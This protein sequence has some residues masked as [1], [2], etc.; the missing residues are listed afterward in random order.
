VRKSK[1]LLYILAA[2]FLTVMIACSTK[3]NTAMSR[4]YHSVTTKYNIL[5]NGR[6][7]YEKGI[8]SLKE[9]YYDDFYNILPVERMQPDEK[10]LVTAKQKDPNFQRAEDKAI[11]ASQLHSIYIAGTENNPQMDEA[12]MLL[13]KSRYHDIR[14]IP[15]IEAFNYIILKY[16][17]SDL[18]YDARVWKEKAN[19][20]LNY[21]NL[22][23]KNLKRLLKEEE[24]KGQTKAD[25]L[26]TLAQG[27]INIEA[28]DSA[29]VPLKEAI[30]TTQDKDEKAR[31][32]YILGQ[33]YGKN[34]NKEEAVKTFQEII[35]YKYRVPRAYVINAHAE[36]FANQDPQK[37]DTVAFLKEYNALLADRE[38][39]GFH[40]VIYH[41]M[42]SLFNFYGNDAQAIANFNKSLKKITTN[43][44]LK[45][46]N[47][48]KLA[49][50]Y[51]AK[52]TYEMAG[53]YYDS[54]LVVMNPNSREY[55]K[56]KRLRNNLV[57]VVKYELVARENDSILRLVALPEEQR[58]QVLKEFLDKKRIADQA[59]EKAAEKGQGQSSVSNSLPMTGGVASSF[60]F[61]S[62]A[63]VQKGKQD[64]S[65]K[66]GKRALTDNW[67]WADEAQNAVANNPNNASATE[68]NASSGEETAATETDMRYNV[69]FFLSQI[70]KDENEIK[71]LKTDR[72]NAYYQLGLLYS[73]LLE[74][75][76]IAADKLETLLTYKPEERLIEPIKY[77]LYKIYLKLDPAKA[78][79]ML[80]DMK[81]NHPN[82]QYTQIILNP[83]AK[84]EID[85]SPVQEYEKIYT[86]YNHGAYSEVLETLNA[87]I[88]T[89]MNDGMVTKYEILKATTIGKLNGLEDYKKALNYVAVTYPNS[90]EGQE[91]QRIISKDL[92]KLQAL[93]FKNDLSKNLKLIYVVDF[94][95]T[96]QGIELRNKLQ[97]YANDRA[98]TGISFSADQ[99]SKDK[100]FLVIHGI[101]SG[102]IAKSAQ[103]YLEIE[104]DYQ[105]KE[106]PVLISSD[107][108]GVV[109]IK[110]NW[111]E[112][113]KSRYGS[114]SNDAQPAQ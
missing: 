3:K 109:L 51:Y 104:R 102:N 60:Y 62:N 29:I 69:D 49:D 58:R 79:A 39:R 98:H 8:E 95:F 107:D 44:Y 4:G 86:M 57:D 18:I 82:S 11:K 42:G 37:I 87:K 110:K 74:E 46:A 71:K 23:I 94:P 41:Q 36:K 6:L 76:Q 13:G 16:P 2:L 47:Y 38:N 72:D 20:R 84:I 31:Y 12:Y 103:V 114:N 19:I 21:D 43:K 63:A 70:P 45:V 61:Y 111:D 88:P 67:R 15:A 112:Y 10:T 5:Y 66:W 100:M 52:K 27:Y 26:A 34:N 24:V 56:V 1:G 7:A 55:L 25:A 89:L 83:N 85:G 97:R 59:A 40:D 65:R 22:A 35:D 91:A 73:D 96:E 93:Q 14:Y 77:N 48:R 33:L 105:I 106:N 28:L 9:K 92:P 101:K 80:E 99:Y 64:F 75:Y 113:M 81:R 90:K 32:T 50:L 108:Y 54:T 17:D 30:E 78:Q 53:K 68:Q